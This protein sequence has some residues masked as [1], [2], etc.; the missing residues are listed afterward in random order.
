MLGK[1]LLDILKES[2]YT[3]VLSGFGMLLESGYPAIR[4]GDE[5]YDVELKYGYS[6]EEIFSSSFYSTRKEQ[7]YEFYRS[8]ILKMLEKP[9][10]KCFYEMAELEK[11]GLIQSV[12]TRRIYGLP[13]RAGCKNVINLHGSVYDNYCPHCGKEYPVEYIVNSAR[14]PLCEVCSTPIRPRICLFGEMVDNRIITKAAEEVRKADVLLVLGTNLKTYLCSQ[15]IDYYEGDKLVLINPEKH[16][17]DKLADVA[18]H[19]SVEDA[20]GEILKELGE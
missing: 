5:S 2:R 12:I 11:R 13:Q 17:S 19:K 1:T 8:E 3:T 18:V 7:F 16:F 10:G 9:P 15:L 6:V 20:L 14:I 4:D